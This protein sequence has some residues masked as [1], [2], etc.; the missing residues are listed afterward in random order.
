MRGPKSAGTGKLVFLAGAGTGVGKL[1]PGKEVFL[2]AVLRGADAA[3]EGEDIF[4]GAAEV[5]DKVSS[6]GLLG[7]P[8]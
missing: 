5:V 2:G 8:L 6:S 4:L 7:P 3:G 1:L